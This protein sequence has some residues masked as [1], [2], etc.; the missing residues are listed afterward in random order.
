MSG[1]IESTNQTATVIPQGNEVTSSEPLSLKDHI[2]SA[3]STPMRVQEI[4]TL[5]ETHGVRIVSSGYLSGFLEALS[6][7]KI[8][9]KKMVDSRPM[10]TTLTDFDVTRRRCDKC[11]KM[12][13]IFGFNIGTQIKCDKCKTEYDV[14]ICI[15]TGAYL[16]R[17]NNG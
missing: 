10:Y 17:I 11:N 8:I 4:G 6:E 9:N 16:K 13:Y 14:K 1:E 15:E 5:L 7:C 2:V 3:L 12:L